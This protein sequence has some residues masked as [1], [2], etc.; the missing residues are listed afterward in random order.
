MNVFYDLPYCPVCTLEKKG[1]FMVNQRLPPEKQITIVDVF[2]NHPSLTFLKKFYGTDDPMEWSVPIIVL[3]RTI[4]KKMF[5]SYIKSIGEKVVIVP[6]S[7]SPMYLADII[8]KI[9][10]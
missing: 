1:I 4:V 8:E 2:S 3:E 10:M 9:L 6:G 7:I 5:N